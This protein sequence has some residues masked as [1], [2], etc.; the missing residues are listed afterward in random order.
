M[1]KI[2]F[3]LL[4]TPFIGNSQ[5][6]YN[7][8]ANIPSPTTNTS[9]LTFVN[10][11]TTGSLVATYSSNTL[12]AVSNGRLANQDGIKL[13]IG[14]VLLV[15]DQAST[16]L[17]NGEFYVAD[18]G[19]TGSKYVLVRPD[20]YDTTTEVYPSQVNVLMG[21][22]NAG[23]YYLQTTIDP[24][25]GTDP[26]VYIVT[27]APPAPIYPLSFIDVHTTAVLP[28]SPVYAAG[29]NTLLP[30]QNATYSA[31][32][33]GTFPTLQGIVASSGLKI[34][35]NNQVDQT[36]NGDYVITSA[37]SATSKW[38][39]TRIS[40]TQSLLYPHLW[41][42]LQGTDKGFIYQQNNKSLVSATIG[43]V[44]NITFTNIN[45]GILT[46]SGVF[47][48]SNSSGVYTYYSTLAAAMSAATSGK[49]IEMFADVTESG[50]V[51]I[52]PKDGVNID[53]HG[54]TYT[55]TNSTVG[56]FNDFSSAPNISI[57]NFNLIVTTYTGYAFTSQ[58]TTI[59]SG[60]YIKSLLG[61]GYSVDAGGQVY[62]IICKTYLVAILISSTGGGYNVYG[63]STLSTYDGSTASIINNGNLYNSVAKRLNGSAGTTLR[64]VYGVG[65]CY[66]CAFYS[67]GDQCAAVDYCY[68]CNATALGAGAFYAGMVCNNCTA[69][70]GSGAYLGIGSLY[71][72]TGTANS[73]GYPLGAVDNCTKISGGTFTCTG[74][75]PV[76]SRSYD[77]TKARMINKTN[78][79]YGVGIYV[80]NTTSVITDCNIEL[81]YDTPCIDAIATAN[82]RYSHN[83][84][85]G[86]TAPVSANVTQYI[87]VANVLDAQGNININH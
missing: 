17:Q 81:T 22:T 16:K 49:T 75:G 6:V 7:C 13:N 30:A 77:V 28:N 57:S 31:T 68:N 78:T 72:S 21:T 2:L 18:T 43:S 79:I 58:G 80:D 25:V 54:H 70:A 64:A 65:K 29:T 10:A 59:G 67:V 34:L 45:P 76:I 74:G 19:T 8:C 1:K 26:I 86:S 52:T 69:T 48:I 38:K 35:V 55:F 27:P 47:G 83:T 23:K 50:A 73:L 63:E 85:S 15:K 87:N 42:V 62:N 84:Y 60:F 61:S 24:I 53:G 9:P 20:Y 56:P 5:I 12:T 66:N 46:V 36:K 44:G 33:N 40:Y 39:L 71:E 14:D 37:G 41:E 32:T 4:I 3:L 51:T 11:S 82:V